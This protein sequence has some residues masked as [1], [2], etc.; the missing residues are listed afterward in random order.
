VRKPAAACHAPASH[1]AEALQAAA[2]RITQPVVLIG[3]SGAGP[4]LPVI[5]DAL[6]GDVAALV[7]DAFL[8][9]SRGGAPL[10]PPAVMGHLRALATDG[11]LPPW[12]SWF[13]EDAMRE[14][15]PD[16]GLR[17]ALEREMPRLPLS[18]F[19]ASI[20]MPPGWSDRAC[21]YLLFS[22]DPHGTSAAGARGRGWPVRDIQG[23][24]HLATVTDPSEVADALLE[25]ERELLAAA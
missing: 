16:T 21:A 24:R 3:H 22:R 5:A 19:E 17:A 25:L 2:E 10:A 12:P 11:V 8:P 7:V 4:L 20:P 18:Y 15:V 14:L 9:P 23:A 1:G 13:G 6:T